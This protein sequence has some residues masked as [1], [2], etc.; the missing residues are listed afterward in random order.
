MDPP[1]KTDV[2]IEVVSLP[3]LFVK[4]TGTLVPDCVPASVLLDPGGGDFGAVAVVVPPSVLAV[5]PPLGPC[6][7]LPSLEVGGGVGSEVVVVG[8]DDRVFVVG[9]GDREVVRGADEDVVGS[10]SDDDVV[11]RLCEEDDGGGVDSADVV[12][13]LGGCESDFVWLI[14]PEVKKM[15]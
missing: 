14:D 15:R 5:V 7:V 8:G 13:A 2:E 12:E 11:L 9:E 1:A 10:P 3:S 4:V 6:E